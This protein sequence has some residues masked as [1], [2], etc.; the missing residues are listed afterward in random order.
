VV[1]DTVYALCVKQ[2]SPF[3]STEVHLVTTAEGAQDARLAL[4]ATETGWFHRLC[5]D[6]R[7]EDISSTPEQIHGIKDATGQPV[8]DIRAKAE[9][10]ACAD[11]ITE[12]V[13][14]FTVD[15]ES[16][17]HVSLA[18][19]RKTMTYY[20]GDA[21]TLFGRPQDRLLHVLVL[22][23]YESNHECF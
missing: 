15:G 16:A 5:R 17:L 20:L 19:G 23:P 10:E 18:G 13:R 6:Y 21:L 11:L 22:P 3:L 1:P 9:H 12:Q 2:D 8:D 14:A 4:L 7:L